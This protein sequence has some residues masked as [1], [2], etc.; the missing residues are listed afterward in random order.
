MTYKLAEA[1]FLL[2][3]PIISSGSFFKS[4]HKYLNLEIIMIYQEVSVHLLIEMD[5]KSLSVRG[6]GE[7]EN[8]NATNSR[9]HQISPKLII[10]FLTLVIPKFRDYIRKAGF[11]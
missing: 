2:F 3:I 7:I 6:A 9:N 8:K 10:H 4:N 11:R 5:Y 1:G